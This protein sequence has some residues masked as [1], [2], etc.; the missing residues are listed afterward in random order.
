MKTLIFKTM[1]ILIIITF[2]AGFL[3]TGLLT[4]E[5]LS[6]SSTGNGASETTNWR[7]KH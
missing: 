4:L 1:R 6:N 2:A 7:S 3:Y 5:N